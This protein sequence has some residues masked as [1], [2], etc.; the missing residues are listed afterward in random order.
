MRRIV[1]PTAAEDGLIEGIMDNLRRVFKAINDRSKLAERTA[2]VTG[3]QLWALK[4]L[5][6]R[7]PLHVSELAVRMFLHPSTV[8]GILDRLEAKGL[9]LRRRLSRD[10]RVVNVE[11]TARGRE[12][13]LRMPAIAQEMLLNGLQTLPKRDLRTVARGLQIQVRLLG[14]QGLPPQLLMSH[15]VNLPRERRARASCAPRAG[16]RGRPARWEG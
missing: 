7:A 5:G 8:V 6:E 15:E 9:A 3:P 1:E 16:T 2:G 10:R 14:A 11:L 12:L 4:V 13:V